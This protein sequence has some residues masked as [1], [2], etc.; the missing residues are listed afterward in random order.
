MA[1]ATEIVT[2]LHTLMFN[3]DQP[4]KHTDWLTDVD[5]IYALAQV[6]WPTSLTA[7]ILFKVAYW[8]DSI[9]R[10]DQAEHV[11]DYLFSNRLRLVQN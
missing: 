8:L 1:T 2:Q 9:G 4:I 11:W 7:D 3:D 10:S 5:K 6:I